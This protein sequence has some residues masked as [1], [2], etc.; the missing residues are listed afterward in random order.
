M[1]WMLAA[2]FG[3]SLAWNDGLAEALDQWRAIK[4]SGI[5]ESMMEA[6]VHEWPLDDPAKVADALA[7]RVA[8]EAAEKIKAAL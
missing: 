7:A 3:R 1:K 8:P 2:G 5:A 4:D 6:F